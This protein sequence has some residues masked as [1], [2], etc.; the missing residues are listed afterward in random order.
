[1]NAR[2]SLDETLG[3][4]HLGQSLNIRYVK[5]VG[6]LASISDAV[7]YAPYKPIFDSSILGGYSNT[8]NVDDFS[9]GN[10]PLAAINLNKPVTSGF[11]FFPQ[12]FAEVDLFAGLRFRTQ[13]SAEIQGGKTTGYQYA[14]A[15]GNNLTQPQTGKT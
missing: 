13:I 10:N 9:N 4:F 2:F 8:T 6:Q 14:Y 1:M 12:V 11:V 7:Y 3:R 15:A 5:D